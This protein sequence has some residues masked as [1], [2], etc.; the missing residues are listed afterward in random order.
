MNNFNFF[1]DIDNLNQLLPNRKRILLFGWLF[2]WTYFIVVLWFLS[3]QWAATFDIFRHAFFLPIGFFAVL[4][5]IIRI[6]T[7]IFLVLLF[8]F[9]SAVYLYGHSTQHSFKLFKRASQVFILVLLLVF[10]TVFLTWSFMPPQ[11]SSKPPTLL[12]TEQVGIHGVPNLAVYWYSDTPSQETLQYGQYGLP[13]SI[14]HTENTLTQ[15]HTFFLTDLLPNTTYWYHVSSHAENYT[16]TTPSA[17]EFRMSIGA[18]LHFG[19]SKLN[20]TNFHSLMQYTQQNNDMSLFLGD[21]TEYGFDSEWNEFFTHMTPYIQ[22]T[23]YA[24]AIGN[25]DAFF[26]NKPLFRTY[27]RPDSVYTQTPNTNY[28]Y[29]RLNAFTHVL[30]LN[31][32]WD[33]RSVTPAQEQW[34]LETLEQIPADDMCFVM[35]HASFLHSSEMQTLLT[36]HAHKIDGFFSGHY[37]IFNT[38]T[39]LDTPFYF[40]GT[41]SQYNIH[42]GTTMSPYPHA[43]MV[44]VI[45][46]A[47]GFSVEYRDYT[48]TT[49]VRYDHF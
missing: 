37:H 26:N 13:N 33:Y 7:I 38:T 41:M 5:E 36:P 47:T 16:F 20:L 49:L 15:Q 43:G 1:D 10:P 18:D 29:L 27:L 25:H 11:T 6:L 19:T 4:G 3:I 2:G 44:D 23:P 40:V 32:K 39:V 35:G 34:I 42:R 12:L 17:N 14:N 30:L 28:H 45:V 31:F 48:N 46:N 9:V 8:L 24:T 22:T 21:L